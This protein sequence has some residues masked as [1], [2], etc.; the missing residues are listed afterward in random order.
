M[1]YRSKAAT[2]QAAG[3][4][5]G[6]H[7]NRLPFLAQSPLMMVSLIFD[8]QPQPYLVNL[9]WFT[10]RSNVYFPD[11]PGPHS[12]IKTCDPPISYFGE[13]VVPKQVPVALLLMAMSTMSKP[14][15]MLTGDAYYW[16][17]IVGHTPQ[18]GWWK[19][20]IVDERTF[21]ALGGNQ[22]F[23]WK[24]HWPPPIVPPEPPPHH[25]SAWHNPARMVPA[26]FGDKG[27]FRIGPSK[28]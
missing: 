24:N 4:A 14:A 5:G 10:R 7:C 12:I 8:G 20:R 27:E 13:I 18:S 2:R 9:A 26:L 21:F 19:H 11:H 25:T 3:T 22:W 28:N 23:D 17:M 1:A 16:M 6:K 15:K